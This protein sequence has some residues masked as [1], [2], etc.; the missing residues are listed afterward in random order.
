MNVYEVPLT[1]TQNPSVI[2]NQNLCLWFA[3]ISGEHLQD[4]WTSGYFSISLAVPRKYQGFALFRQ[5]WQC[6]E[7]ITDYWEKGSIYQLG[8]PTVRGF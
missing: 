2:C 4:H 7:N 1:C 6:N 3:Q 8:V 5:I